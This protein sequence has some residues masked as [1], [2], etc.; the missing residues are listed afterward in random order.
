MGRDI[1]KYPKVFRLGHKNTN[2]IFSEGMVYVEEKKVDEN[3]VKYVSVY[4]RV[5]KDELTPRLREKVNKQYK[6]LK[7]IIP[8]LEKNCVAEI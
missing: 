4:R 1:P 8:I 5:I 3:G 7:A 6:I 2:G